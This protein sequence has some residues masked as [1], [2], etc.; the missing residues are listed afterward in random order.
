MVAASSP[1]VRQTSTQV[2]T[3]KRL[4]ARSDAALKSSMAF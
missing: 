4:A 1:T 2:A 3:A